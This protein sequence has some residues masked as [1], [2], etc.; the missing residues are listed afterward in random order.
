MEKKPKHDELESLFVNNEKLEKIDSFLSRFNPIRVMK[1]ERMEIRH[2]AILAWLLDPK[3]SHGLND[4]FLKAFLGEALRGQQHLG[5]PTALDISQSDL[6]D[7]EVRCEW[8]NIDIFIYSQSNYWAFIVENKFDSGQHGGQLTKYIDKILSIYGQKDSQLHI[9]GI[10]LTL[11]DE[12]P[13]DSRYVPILYETICEFFPRFIE[14]ES[15]KLSPEV[16]TFLNHYLEVLRDSTDMNEESRRMEKLARELYRDHKKVLDFVMEHGAGSDFAIAARSLFGDDPEDLEKIEIEGEN[17]RFGSMANDWVSFLPETW[18]NALGKDKLDWE[19]CEEWWEGYPLISWMEI[20]SGDDGKEGKIRLY[21]EVGP[22][23]EHKVRSALIESIK[24]AGLEMSSS[25]ISFQRTAT[26]EGKKFS[27]FLKNNI[28]TVHD[29]QDPEEIET[30][31]KN[32]LRRFRPEI[33]AIAA[34]LPPY[35]K[36]GYVAE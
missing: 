30:A 29:V 31:M 19:G 23:S 33:E 17:F 16:T 25:K 34:I 24:S 22:L 35:K 6:R 12:E 27:K 28:I 9:R 13:E 20:R 1:M 10:F 21:A 5:Y 15:S 32:L 2:S 14:Q 3:E 36:H 18:Y 7:T 8:Q 11:W 4:K 26:N